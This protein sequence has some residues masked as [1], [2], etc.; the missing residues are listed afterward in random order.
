MAYYTWSDCN[1][2]WNKAQLGWSSATS[3]PDSNYYIWDKCNLNWNTIDLTWDDVFFLIQ[4][5]QTF[6]G[7]GYEDYLL[8][9]KPEV[10]KRLIKI[11]AKVDG[12][13][14][15]NEAF[16]RKDI[17]VIVKNVQLLVEHFTGIKIQVHV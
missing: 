16:Q 2:D 9:T 17:K 8:N 1:V 6:I 10:K 3:A 11:M 13:K 4:I 5:A 7:P 15:L 14:H 12:E